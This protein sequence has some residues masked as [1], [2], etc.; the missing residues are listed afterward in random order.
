M[1][2]SLISESPT[3]PVVENR[4]YVD[5]EIRINHLLA[6]WDR[7]VLDGLTFERCWILGPAVLAVVDTDIVCDHVSDLGGLPDEPD[8]AILWPIG[9]ETMIGAILVVR[10]T[11]RSCKFRGIGFT[12]S[13]ETIELLRGVL[14]TPT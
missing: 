9:R 8:R 7:P 10:C 3:V 12:G 13:D 2:R 14:N 1:G 6:D 4:T 5:T 11:F